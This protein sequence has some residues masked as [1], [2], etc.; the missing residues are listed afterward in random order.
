MKATIKVICGDTT[1]EVETEVPVT[2]ELLKVLK[3]GKVSKYELNSGTL[4][5]RSQNP[6]LN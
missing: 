6:S 2:G 3:I 5:P 4:K 1:L